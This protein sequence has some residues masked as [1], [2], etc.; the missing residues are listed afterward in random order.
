MC[1]FTQHWSGTLVMYRLN[2]LPK[3][4]KQA[5]LLFAVSGVDNA[6]KVSVVVIYRRLDNTEAV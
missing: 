4:S 2:L 6:S 3:I 5:N 1:K